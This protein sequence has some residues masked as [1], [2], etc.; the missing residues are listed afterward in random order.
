[1][2]N[3]LTIAKALVVAEAAGRCSRDEQAMVRYLNVAPRAG[4]ATVRGSPPLAPA[5]DPA[6]FDSP[7]RRRLE[8][9]LASLAP[10]SR[11]ELIALAH[12]A[13]AADADFAKAMRRARRIPAAA[14]IGYLMGR[15][16]ERQIPVALDKLGAKG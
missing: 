3:A 12:L 13:R 4:A 2:L 1:M 10:E 15:P 9:L 7:E 16:L 8:A 5:V 14:Q 11:L 6:A